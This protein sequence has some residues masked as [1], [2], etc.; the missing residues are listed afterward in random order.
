MQSLLRAAGLAAILCA[1]SLSSASAEDPFYLGQWKITG[2]VPGPWIKS[3][4]ELF[5]DEM[6][7]LVGQTIVLKP[8]AVEGPGGFPCQG[9]KYEVMQGGPDM[10]FQGAFGEMQAKNAS[11]DPQKL[12]E[13]VGLT[14][15]AYRTVITGCEFAVDFSFGADND[16]A[17]FAL[18]NAVYVLKRQ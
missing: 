2:A 8:G 16:T 18:D 3:D 9:P 13:Q 5:P 12:A 4:A 10:L 1:A 15:T 14:G 7:S 11:V 17:M 6:K